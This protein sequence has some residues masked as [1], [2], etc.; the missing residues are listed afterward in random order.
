MFGISLIVAAGLGVHMLRK[1]YAKRKQ[2]QA[3]LAAERSS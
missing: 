3:L 2:E 1:H